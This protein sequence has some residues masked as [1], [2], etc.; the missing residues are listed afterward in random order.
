MYFTNNFYNFYNFY[1]RINNASKKWG[2][3]TENQKRDI[4]VKKVLELDLGATAARFSRTLAGRLKGRR[5]R[6][7]SGGITGVTGQIVVR[8]HVIQGQGF[9][10]RSRRGRRR[11]PANSPSRP[12]KIRNKLKK[13]PSTQ[14]SLQPKPRRPK[15]KLRVK[16]KTISRK[17][18]S[19]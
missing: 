18:G 5:G 11:F 12:L 17:E 6:I 8:I 1:T 3:T 7:Q 4:S 14:K 13:K 10:S 16:Q 19:H 9:F 2:G 15:K